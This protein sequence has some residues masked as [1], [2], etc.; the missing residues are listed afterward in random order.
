[1]IIKT[2]PARDDCINALGGDLAAALKS[3]LEQKGTASLALSGGRSPQKVL[4]LLASEPLRWSD[5]DVTLS[6]ERCVL[7]TDEDS[8]AAMV[9]ACFL[10]QGA[11]NASFHPLWRQ[12]IDIV[13]GLEIARS[14][15]RTF[16][17]PLDVIYLGMGEDG[18]FASLFPSDDIAQ[19][20]NDHGP[21]VGGRAPSAPHQRISLSLS[22]ILKTRHL[23]LHVTGNAKRETFEYARTIAPTSQCPISLL[24]NNDEIDLRV[25]MADE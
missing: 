14:E 19:F 22:T 10:K 11:Q 1:M 24:L 8:N 25:Y 15:L 7:P 12:D 17:W 5:I 23:F 18:H 9:Q 4:P 6:D 3:A 2:F 20:D 13:D 16:P 21:V